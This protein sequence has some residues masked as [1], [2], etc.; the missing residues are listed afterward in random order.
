MNIA[1]YNL[2]EEKTNIISNNQTITN[3]KNSISEFDIKTITEN[4]IPYN[5]HHIENIKENYIDLNKLQLSQP[6]LI[7]TFYDA[8]QTNISKKK[9]KKNKTNHFRKNM[10]SKLD[11]QTIDHMIKSTIGLNKPFEICEGNIKFRLYSIN[12]MK[13]DYFTNG[14]YFQTIENNDNTTLGIVCPYFVG[15]FP[16]FK[17]QESNCLKEKNFINEH[18]EFKFVSTF[19]VNK[20]YFIQMLNFYFALV[21]DITRLKKE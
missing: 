18:Y 12:M 9:I 6:E 19:K 13:T 21:S 14:E 11:N 17:L 16:E 7:K 5:I 15:N 20:N 4:Y 8:L 2:D 1:N 10:K 3:I